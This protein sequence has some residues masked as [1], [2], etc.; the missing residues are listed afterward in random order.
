MIDV[1]RHRS[2]RST[3]SLFAIGALAIIACCDRLPCDRHTSSSLLAI[4]VVVL[5]PR[6][7]RCCRRRYLRWTFVVITTTRPAPAASSEL[8]RL[9]KR[10]GGAANTSLLTRFVH[11]LPIYRPRNRRDHDR[12]HRDRRLRDRRVSSLQKLG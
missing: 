5:V 9:T 11:E 7:R 12:R 8:S 3:S 6:D 10:V 4:D 2:S 1:R